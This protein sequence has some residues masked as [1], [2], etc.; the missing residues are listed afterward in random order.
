MNFKKITATIAAVVLA[1]GMAVG[2]V[3]TSASATHPSVS[4]AAVCNTGT[5]LYDVTWT[6]TGDTSNGYREFEGVIQYSSRLQSQLVGETVKGATV[7]AIATETVSSKSTIH[8]D[9]S[10]KFSNG[11]KASNTGKVVIRDNCAPVVKIADPLW[12]YTPPTCEVG[13]DIRLLPGTGYTWGAHNA[14][15]G[16]ATATTINRNTFFNNGTRNFTITQKLEPK[17]V[18][19]PCAGPQPE[20]K[21][22]SS[23]WVDGDYVCADTTV[24]QTRT[25]SVTTYSLVGNSWV[26]N[27]PVVKPETQTRVLSSEE[28]QAVCPKPEPEKVVVVSTGVYDCDDTTVDVTTKTTYVGHAWNGTEWALTPQPTDRSKTEV[29]S[30]ALTAEEIEAL[31]CPEVVIPPTEPP[32]V[33]PP[34][35]DV[36][37]APQPPVT[38]PTASAL[39]TTGADA[40]PLGLFGVLMLLAGAS[41][42]AVRKLRRR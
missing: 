26:A 20:D 21:V 38:P 8:L 7:V 34:V 23:E 25:V 5:G 13:G 12:S 1:T 16:Q 27:D 15:T 10:V 18:G 35:V 36:P 4:G 28:R 17:L 14:N 22:I 30:R 33:V 41:V 40:L 39:P 9:V 19:L 37:K 2:G 11:H 31:D 32:V 6:I 24:E 29:T 42:L 3:A